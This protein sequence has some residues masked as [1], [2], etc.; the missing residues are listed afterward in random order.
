MYVYLCIRMLVCMHVCVYVYFYYA[1]LCPLLLGGAPDHSNCMNSV[2]VYT[3]K[4]YRQPYTAEVSKLRGAGRIRPVKVSN[5]ARGALPENINM[6]QKTVND[7]GNY[8]L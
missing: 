2:G 1:P 6:G 7:F 4:G 3:T 5:L 8:P